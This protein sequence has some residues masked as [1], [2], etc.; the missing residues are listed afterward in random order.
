MNTRKYS[1]SELVRVMMTAFFFFSQVTTN[2]DYCKVNIEFTLFREIR[3][4]ILSLSSSSF[5]PFH[6][7]I[8]YNCIYPV[9]NR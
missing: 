6:F 7:T 1:D 8:K 9:Y 3:L 5:F 4:G 2:Y